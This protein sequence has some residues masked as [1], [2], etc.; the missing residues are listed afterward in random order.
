M[1]ICYDE[2]CYFITKG[3]AC[4]QPDAFLYDFVLHLQPK[5]LVDVK[6]WVDAGSV[7]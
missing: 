5:D 4:V 3:L 1:S 2:H 7:P 6:H